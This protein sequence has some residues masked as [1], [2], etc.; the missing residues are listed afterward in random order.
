MGDKHYSVRLHLR[1]V[2]RDAQMRCDTVELHTRDWMILDE[3]ENRVTLIYDED[4][5]SG[6]RTA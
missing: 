5:S 6:C 3:S 1:G 4:E 2:M